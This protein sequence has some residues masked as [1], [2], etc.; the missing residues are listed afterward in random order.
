MGTL[1][2]L[3]Y[4]PEASELQLVA[5]CQ[6]GNRK[7]QHE[8]YDRYKRAMYTLAFRLLNNREEAEDALQEGFVKVFRGLD[9]FRAESSLGAWIRIIV[10]RACLNRLKVR[11]KIETQ[12]MEG[13]HPSV[14]WDANLT[15]EVLHRAISNLSDGYRTVFVMVEVEGYSHKEVAQMLDISVTT[16]RSQLFHAKKRLQQALKGFHHTN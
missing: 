6:A 12:S 7:A 16:S 9:S 1:R 3:H 11:M 2:N 13:V 14:N 15:G 5:N 10:T 4:Q 8:L